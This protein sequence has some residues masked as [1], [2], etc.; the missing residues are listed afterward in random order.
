MKISLKIFLLSLVGFFF[1]CSAD[2]DISSTELPAEESS[3]LTINAVRTTNQNQDRTVSFNESIQIDSFML[4]IEEIEF[5]F[6]D[7]FGNGISSPDD[8]DDSNDDDEYLEFDELPQEI[9][10]Y[11]TTNYPN[12]PLCEAELEDDLDDPY[13]YEVELQSGTE[14]YFKEDFSLYAVETDDEGCEDEDDYDEDDSED[15]DEYKINGPFEIDLTNESTTV[16]QVEIPVA[17]YE[18]VEFEMD[19]GKDMSSPL[20]QKSMLMTGTLNG[21]PFEFY[22]TFS[23]DF[24]ID[25]EDAGQNLV[26]TEENN[27]EI[28]F[29]FDLISVIN[30][31]NMNNASD[32]NGNGVIEISPDDTDGNNQLANQIK[33]AVKD[34]VDLID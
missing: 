33:N 16:V 2:D 27:N 28:T 24:E 8:N 5:E 23:E 6:A 9:Q 22:H 7:G 21:M 26:I 13:R 32:G 15:E 12:D 4:N 25:Y 17:E 30:S 10:D 31:V 11:L 19:R 1:S 14:L 34:Y 20:Y 29:Q 18:E 3:S